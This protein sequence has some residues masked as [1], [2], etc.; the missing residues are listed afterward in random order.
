MSIATSILPWYAWGMLP[1][2]VANVLINHLLAHAHF[3]VVPALVLLAGVYA[4]ALTQFHGSFVAVL[5]TFGA[6][7]V[8][9]LAIAA[10]FTWRAPK[11]GVG[12]SAPMI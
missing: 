9:L 12:G 3:R 2:A 7:N 10:W 6:S 5:Q 4:F 8:A 11:S 1:L